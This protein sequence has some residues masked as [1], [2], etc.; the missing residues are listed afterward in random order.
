M[1]TVPGKTVEVISHATGPVAFET[2]PLIGFVLLFVLY[3]TASSEIF[4][5]CID[6]DKS[7]TC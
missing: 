6:W 1:D 4:V 7:L 2:S 3:K 5:D